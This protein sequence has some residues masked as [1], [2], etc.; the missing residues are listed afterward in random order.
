MEVTAPCQLEL[1]VNLPGRRRET[2]IGQERT[3]GDSDRY[4]TV[5]SPEE[6]FT[7]IPLS[8]IQRYPFRVRVFTACVSA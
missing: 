3:I 4:I 2:R 6:C 7:R 1:V 8:S 5:A